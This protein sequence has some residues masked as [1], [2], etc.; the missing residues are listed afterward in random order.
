MH[1][2][3]YATFAT[4]IYGRAYHPS[5]ESHLQQTNVIQKWG[6]D[7][8]VKSRWR[9][10]GRKIVY[11]INGESEKLDDNNADRLD[12]AT[13]GLMRAISTSCRV[14]GHTKEAAKYARQC[15]F[16][17][18]D[19]YELNSLFL[20]TTPDD[21]CSFGVRLYSKSQNWVSL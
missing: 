17:M 20:S 9:S 1:S 18:L 6:N 16:A 8:Q 12:A 3:V 11:I 13:K 21:E 10:T 15:C 14:M 7:M 5:Y 2:G 19:Y 4:S